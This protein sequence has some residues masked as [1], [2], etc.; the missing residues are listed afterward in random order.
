[1]SMDFH[2]PIKDVPF[3]TSLLGAFLLVF[4]LYSSFIKEKL[5]LSEAL[6]TTIL[7]SLVGPYVGGWLLP[8]SWEGVNEILLEFS[9]T[10]L[11]H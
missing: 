1:M 7:G 6:L 5:Y 10:K 4:G 11:V 2:F 3:A 8:Y 9:N